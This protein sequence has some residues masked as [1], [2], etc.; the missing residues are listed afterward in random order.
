MIFQFKQILPF[1]TWC[2]NIAQKENQSHKWYNHF[3]SSQKLLR[4]VHVHH[5]WKLYMVNY[6]MRNQYWDKVTARWMRK[7]K[8]LVESS[9]LILISYESSQNLYTYMN[10]INIIYIPNPLPRLENKIQKRKEI[11][12]WWVSIYISVCSLM[13]PKSFRRTFK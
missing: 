5:T 8:I 3:C 6:H 4:C 10:I 13:R 12:F 9:H 2:M 11:S 7:H 1:T